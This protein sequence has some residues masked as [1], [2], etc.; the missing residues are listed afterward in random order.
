MSHRTLAVVYIGNADA[1]RIH[2]FIAPISLDLRLDVITLT[3]VLTK[4]TNYRGTA[5]RKT[6]HID[7]I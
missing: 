1:G 7:G 3:M 5:R 2:I 4:L 6:V